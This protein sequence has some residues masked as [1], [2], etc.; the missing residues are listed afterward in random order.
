M[1]FGDTLVQFNIFKA[2]K[3]PVE[4]TSLFGIDLIDEL[5]VGNSDILDCLESVFEELDHDEPWGV[6]DA[7]VTTALAHLEHDSKSIYSI[8]QVLKNEKLEC[9]K[10]LEVQ[11]A[12][13]TKQQSTQIAN[14]LVENESADIS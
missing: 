4:D 10:H 7:K 14:T 8:D 1:E 11:V 2:M 5:V 3:H 12:G 6:H 13:T 9:S